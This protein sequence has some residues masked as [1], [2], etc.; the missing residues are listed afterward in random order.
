VVPSAR[1]EMI[2]IE[3]H[4]SK[5]LNHKGLTELK[6]MVNRQL[7]QFNKSVKKPEE[8]PEEKIREKTQMEE[9]D[10]PNYEKNHL[11]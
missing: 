5:N 4:N 1:K 9:N 2:E 11:H 8:D 10:L 6:E 3:V 7:E